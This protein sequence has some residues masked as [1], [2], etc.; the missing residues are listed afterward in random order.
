MRTFERRGDGGL[1][2]KDGDCEFNVPAAEVDRKRNWLGAMGYTSE[3]VVAADRP[4]GKAQAGRQAGRK[5][6]T[7]R[8]SKSK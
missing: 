1:T 8:K 5:K 2:I 4:A 3:A 6:K 7:V